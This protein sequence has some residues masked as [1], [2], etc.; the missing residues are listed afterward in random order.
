MNQRVFAVPAALALVL[1]AVPAA[2][3]NVQG[4][5]RQSP[6]AMVMQ[7]VG[8]S[9]VTV[10]YHRPSVN[11]R[12]VWGALVPYGAVWRAGAND[13]TT[14]RLSDDARVEG[15][16]LAAG[17]YGVHMIPG[18]DKWTIAF[19][20]VSTAWGS[21]TYDPAED[22][23]RVEVEPQPSEFDERLRYS[24]DEVDNTR[25][26]VALHWEKLRV[27][28]TVEFA[29][30]DLIVAKIERDLR[31]LP[32]FSWQGW[33]SAAGWTLQN[34]HALDKGL[35]WAER[36]IT[37][38]EN[39]QNLTTKMAILTRLDRADEAKPVEARILEIGNE[40]QINAL[41]YTHLFQLQ[42][43]QRAVEVFR[44]NTVDHPESW[45]VWDSLGE[46]LAAT[47]DKAG[48]IEYYSKALAMAPENQKA[49]IEGVLNGL[50]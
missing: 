35:E 1:L 30:N 48:A 20:N 31:H 11:N 39:G 9:N 8:V 23:L 24:V 21:F 18:R 49:R 36:S 43:P 10:H 27:P 45:N 41:G 6:E 40:A 4:L 17:T 5:P 19:S 2:A 22:A 50:K 44:K 47:G 42:N 16:P 3:Q 26:T 32:Q 46:G 37:M 12:E 33:N 13:N 38:N 28:F 25:A 15:Q 14:I 29:T 7:R 34:G